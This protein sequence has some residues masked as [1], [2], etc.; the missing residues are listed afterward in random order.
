M[1]RRAG[2]ELRT[3]NSIGHYPSMGLAEA[4]YARSDLFEKRR[5]L[6]ESWASYLEST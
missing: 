5:I 2:L 6:M 3:E 1:Y 4:A